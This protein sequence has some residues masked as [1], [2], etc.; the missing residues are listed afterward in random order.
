[1]DMFGGKMSTVVPVDFCGLMDKIANLKTSLTLLD[2]NYLSGKRYRLPF[3]E[4][5]E[6]EAL[7]IAQ[8]VYDVF[9]DGVSEDSVSLVQLA[10][11]ERLLEKGA[12]RRLSR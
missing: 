2:L 8:E 12:K 6:K 10:R 11:M 7:P 3:C 9:K 4:L 1:M 5:G